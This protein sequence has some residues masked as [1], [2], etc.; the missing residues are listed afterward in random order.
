MYGGAAAIDT[1]HGLYVRTAQGTGPPG[2]LAVWRLSNSSSANP[3]VT[4]DFA[5]QLLDVN[6]TPVNVAEGASIAYDSMNDQFVIW[7]SL[8]RGT[9]WITNA[10]FNLD[11]SIAQFWT[12]KRMLSTT[13]MQP[14]GNHLRTVLGKWKYAP[15]LRAFVALDSP[16]ESGDVWLYK[17]PSR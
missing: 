6:G 5:V 12:V 14:M 1:Q 8:D 7:D 4:R 2:D 16:A 11:G 15:E 17:P 13:V 9:V 3:E 10:S